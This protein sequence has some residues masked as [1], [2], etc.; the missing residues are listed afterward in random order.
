MAIAFVDSTTATANSTDDV[1]V[2][3]PSISDDNV[4]LMVYQHADNDSMPWDTDPANNGWT[5]IDELEEATGSDQTW[6]LWYRVAS[7]EP[8]NYTIAGSDTTAVNCS[9]AIVGYSGVDTSNPIDTAYV[10]ATHYVR[11]SNTTTPD[12]AAVTTTTDGAFVVVFVLTQQNGV[13]AYTPSSG[14]TERVDLVGGSG[15]GISIADDEITT[16]GAEN[17]GTVAV[18]GGAATAQPAVITVALRPAAE[19]DYSV[20]ARRR[21]G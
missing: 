15:Q 20:T 8:A 10:R 18:T 14:Y 13:T 9:A 12:P 3:V 21:Y 7:S 16:A 2:S 17:P 5:L 6:G 11:A 4:M 1:T 19:G